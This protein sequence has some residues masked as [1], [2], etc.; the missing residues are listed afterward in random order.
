MC[1]IVI[2]QN[3]IQNPVLRGCLCLDSPWT[4]GP[5]KGSRQSFGKCTRLR[6]TGE[7][8]IGKEGKPVQGCVTEL[9]TTVGDWSLVPQGSLGGALD[10]ST[11]GM[12]EGALPSRSFLPL[13]KDC[14]TWH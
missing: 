12:G 10:E 6:G 14:S 3:P 11:S 4:L 13:V 7:N 2:T 9:I 8:K 1:L 5:E